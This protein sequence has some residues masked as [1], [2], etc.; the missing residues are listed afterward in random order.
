MRG[1]ENG[2]RWKLSK[3]GRDEYEVKEAKAVREEGEREMVIDRKRGLNVQ[4]ETWVGAKL[5]D[6]GIGWGGR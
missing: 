3:R 5:M 1:R 6:G 2:K 4:R